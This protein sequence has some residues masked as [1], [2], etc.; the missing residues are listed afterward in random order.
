V[1]QGKAFL[2]PNFVYN[3]FAT[4]LVCGIMLASQINRYIFREVLAP[5]LLCIVI[6]TLVMVMGQ[7][8][9]LVDLIISKGVSFSDILV[10]LATLLPTVFSI[11]LPLSFLMGI[12]IGLGRM[13][14]DSE[15]VA[16][17]SA[18]IGLSNIAIPVAALGIIF[19][20][21]TG[22]TSLW[23]KPWGY[24][25]FAS[26]SFEIAR[27]NATVGF[28][29]RI[30]MKQFNDLVLYANDIEGR[31]GTMRGLFIVEEQATAT[32]WVFA[33]SGRVY[34]D[35]ESK[36]LTLKLQNGVIQR[37][38]L[39]ASDEYQLIHFRNYEIQPRMATPN[40]AAARRRTRP[41]EL[42]TAALWQGIDSAQ[43]PL[44]R[45]ELQAEL[46]QRLTS[47]LAPMIFVLFGLPFSIQSHRSGR[48]G[49]FVVGLLFFVAYYFL[50]SAGFTLTRDAALPP[51][52]SYWLPHLLLAVAGSIFLYQS[53]LERTNRIVAL[54]DQIIYTLQKKVRKHVDA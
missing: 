14:A 10:L 2:P 54:V 3:P 27:Q 6:F 44:K 5:T 43:E 39:D 47:A 8:L 16:L 40:G 41:W 34:S 18:G 20:L 12:M 42:S 35:A 19:T 37:Q 51:W 11:S 28:Q 50:L 38:P 9:K 32:A 36:T 52:L 53:S 15:T 33:E 30:F 13:S 49:G 48:S 25:I 7:S 17:K 23:V 46:H 26:K 4:V 24:D 45:R 1:P 21:L 22:I 29:P 31:S